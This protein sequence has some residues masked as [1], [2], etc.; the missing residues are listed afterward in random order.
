MALQKVVN[1]SLVPGV[2]GEFS[3]GAVKEA[4]AYM[5]VG[6]DGKKPAEFG[7]FF[8]FAVAELDASTLTFGTMAKQGI[9]SGA[10]AMGI[11]VNP[12][13][14][15]V[16]GFKTSRSIPSGTTATVANRG[17][18]WVFVNESVTA[19]G[20]VYAKADGTPTAISSGNTL[21]KGAKWLNT[22][23]VGEGYTA[24]SNTAAYGKGDKI[25]KDGK[26]YVAIVDILAPEYEGTN[27]FSEADW[28]EVTIEK[29][30]EIAI[31][32]PSI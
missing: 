3:D 17:H 22:V 31:D 7:K 18:I 5:V 6:T 1:G 2:V 13:E 30:A 24:W 19:G 8:S 26:Y 12:K 16:V 10:K 23:T 32:N 27:T 29:L 11:L 15:Y 25:S 4:R 14:H 9:T 28:A 21:V 20:A